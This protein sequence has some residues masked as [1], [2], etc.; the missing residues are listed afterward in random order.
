MKPSGMMPAELAA[1]DGV[2]RVEAAEDGLWR[3]HFAPG[4]DPTDTLVAL[5]V[6]RR[7][8]L[9]RLQPT[10]TSLEEV[11]VHLTRSEALV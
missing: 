6:E 5:A 7:W 9:F 2:S 4:S 1:I 3:L 11:F 8:G 10:Q